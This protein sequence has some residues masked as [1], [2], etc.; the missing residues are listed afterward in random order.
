M[1][2]AARP[3]LLA[4]ALLGVAT[5]GGCQL[6]PRG[7][8]ETDLD[9][10][11]G[12][13]CAEQVCVF[14]GRSDLYAACVV[15]RDCDPY[16]ECMR[17]V[18][19]LARGR[20][21]EVLDCAAWEGCEENVCRPLDGRCTTLD[22]CAAWE[23]CYA[24]ASTNPPLPD[25]RCGAAPGR[26][27]TATDCG[28]WQRC[29][30][31]HFCQT[32]PGFCADDAECQT[33]QACGTTTHVCAPRPGRCGGPN[34]CA[35]WQTCDAANTCVTAPGFC[36][37]DASCETWKACGTDH[38]C[39]LRPGACDVQDDCAPELVCAAHACVAQP[40][41]PALDPALVHL[42]GTVA[43]GT[44]GRAAIAPLGSAGKLVGLAEGDL[45]CGARLAPDQ[46]VLVSRGASFAT[47]VADSIAWDA[48]G[49]AWTYPAAPASNDAAVEPPAGCAGAL[50]VTVVLRAGTGERVF[51][52]NG[53]WLEAAG[54]PVPTGG[55]ALLAWNAAGLLLTGAEDT[56]IAPTLRDPAGNVIAL[57]GAS[58]P[59]GDRLVSWRAASDGFHVVRALGAT[60]QVLDELQVWT[61][62]ADGTTASAA[63][64][65]A[66]PA[67]V[68][69]ADRPVLDATGD[70][71]QLARTDAG[72]VV[73]RRT[74]G[75]TEAI[76]VHDEA[77]LPPPAMSLLDARVHAVDGACLLTGP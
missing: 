25:H 17:G 38:L 12:R 73:V 30:V 45:A 34:D 39:A 47:L 9:C 57:T 19:V 59:P 43:P 61:I 11:S 62:A 10:D 13:H 33:W 50:S 77:N 40:A 51:G 29:D 65:P 60:P 6:A 71:F 67:G 4:V 42:V 18:C 15:D 20:C 58:M 27:G 37:D 16:A 8:C 52:C 1:A 21:A 74:P 55:E 69:A 41:P 68:T 31:V 46:T 54:T 7:S 76:V 22:D 56:L 53:G 49:D 14:D 44:P 2:R 26:C 72:P 48:N 70:V 35:S 66:L 23:I 28:S 36:A 3:T 63:P 75:S 64:L 5:L 24:A 32:A